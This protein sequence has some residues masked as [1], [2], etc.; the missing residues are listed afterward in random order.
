M[1]TLKELNRAQIISAALILVTGIV[2]VI[3]ININNL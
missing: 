2:L 1:K 3:S